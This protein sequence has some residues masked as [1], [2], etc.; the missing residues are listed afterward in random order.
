[1]DNYLIQQTTTEDITH[2]VLEEKGGNKGPNDKE[3]EGNMY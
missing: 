3:E 2:S 1:M